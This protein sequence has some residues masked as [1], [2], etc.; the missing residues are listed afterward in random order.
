MVC[1]IYFQ[2]QLFLLQ[3]GN[4]DKYYIKKNKISDLFFFEMLHFEWTLILQNH[5]VHKFSY[6]C[7]NVTFVQTSKF[8]LEKGFYKINQ[9]NHYSPLLILVILNG[10]YK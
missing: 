9:Q 1:L 5:I 2:K 4:F 10:I 8:S 6:T 3:I 7:F